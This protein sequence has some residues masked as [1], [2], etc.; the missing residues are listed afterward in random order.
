MQ[1]YHAIVYVPHGYQEPAHEP[2]RVCGHG[3]EYGLY[4]AVEGHQEDY[5]HWSQ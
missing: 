4:E 1:S 2:I 5:L 3:K